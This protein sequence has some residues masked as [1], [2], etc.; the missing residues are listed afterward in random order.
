[1]FYNGYSNSVLWPFFHALET[2][3]SKSSDWKAY[4]EVNELFSESVITASDY[5]ADIWVHD[6]QLL[7]LPKL[8]REHRPNNKIGFFMH[9]PFPPPEHFETLEQGSSLVQGLLGADLIGFHTPA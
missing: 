4:R 6:Y 5:S 2:D 3:F 7:L 9:I 8:L 1:S